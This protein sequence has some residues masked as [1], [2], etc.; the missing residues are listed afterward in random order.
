MATHAE[1]QN[2][3]LLK[4]IIALEFPRGLVSLELG[5]VD[6]TGFYGQKSQTI[7]VVIRR[8][9]SEPVVLKMSG[10]DSWRELAAER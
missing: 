3:K 6:T 8:K 1:T 7:E 2:R 10:V 9:G 4:G 5:A